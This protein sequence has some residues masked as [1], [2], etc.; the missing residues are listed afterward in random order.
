[1][2]AAAEVTAVAGTGIRHPEKGM[3]SDTGRFLSWL[4]SFLGGL[5]ALTGAS[6]VGW[7][8]VLI[9]YLVVGRV[10][11]GE[12]HPPL[13]TVCILLVIGILLLVAG[14]VVSRPR[15]SNPG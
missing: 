10:K 1:M 12:E 5:I 2:N 11:A 14:Y 15:A 7:Q 3:R 4:R 8:T 6:L 13:V 9:Y